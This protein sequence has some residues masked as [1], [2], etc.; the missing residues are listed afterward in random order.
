MDGG[1]GL[2]EVGQLNALVFSDKDAAMEEIRWE[3]CDSFPVV[4]ALDGQEGKQKTLYIQYFDSRVDRLEE[5]EGTERGFRRD[6]KACAGLFV[7]PWEKI[8][9]T[10]VPFGTERCYDS[11]GMF[12]KSWQ[13][14][15]AFS[16]PIIP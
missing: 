7:G 10:V 9:R 3:Y 5:R 6:E 11:L 15:M 14:V 2:K 13:R 8:S 4:T 16:F 1:C 12:A